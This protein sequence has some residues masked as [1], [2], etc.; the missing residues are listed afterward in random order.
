MKLFHLFFFSIISLI[1]SIY[2]FINNTKFGAILS[3]IYSSVFL[4]GGIANKRNLK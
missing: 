3:L 4:I 1:I 2:Q